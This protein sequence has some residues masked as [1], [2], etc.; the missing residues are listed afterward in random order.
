MEPR[1]SELAD[2]KTPLER[3]VEEIRARL[4]APPETCS[5]HVPREPGYGPH[6]GVGCFY[7]RRGATGP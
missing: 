6:H 4:A 3:A 1:L 2:G 5:C 7:F